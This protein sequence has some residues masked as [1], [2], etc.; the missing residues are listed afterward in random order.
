MVNILYRETEAV[1]S[2]GAISR[3]SRRL[4]FWNDLGGRYL[5]LKERFNTVAKQWMMSYSGMRVIVIPLFF[6]FRVQRPPGAEPY[7]TYWG[8]TSSTFKNPQS[9]NG[10]NGNIAKLTIIDGDFAALDTRANGSYQRPRVLAIVAHSTTILS[11]CSELYA[12]LVI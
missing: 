8:T 1:R 12:Q 11:D 4:S 5:I 6:Y 10:W 9:F 3:T 7:N 2:E